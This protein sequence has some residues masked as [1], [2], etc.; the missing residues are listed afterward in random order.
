MKEKLK[1]VIEEYQCSGCING[2]GIKCFESNGNGGIGCGKH[3]AGTFVMQI[4]KIFLGMPRGFNR[5]GVQ[6]ELVPLI[7][8]TFESFDWGQ[9]DKWNVPTWKYLSK[10]GHTFVRGIV[11][12]KNEP[13]LH[14]FLENCIDKIDCLEINQED[15]DYM[16]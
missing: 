14:I 12:R 11:P 8:E 1:N 3:M 9:Y 13:F 6:A 2:C 4:G 16:D 10:E 15:V 5:L 7:F